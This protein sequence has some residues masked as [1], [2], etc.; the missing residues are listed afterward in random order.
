VPLER[1]NF[2]GSDTY[3]LRTPLLI[4]KSNSKN[5]KHERINITLG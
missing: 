2:A 4:S 1:D 5:E 3:Y